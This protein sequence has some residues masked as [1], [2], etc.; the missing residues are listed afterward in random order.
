MGSATAALLPSARTSVSIAQ[1]W[2]DVNYIL[3]DTRAFPICYA[4][5]LYLAAVSVISR[6]LSMMVR[7]SLSCDSVMHNGGTTKIQFQRTKV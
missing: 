2:S 5:P 4:G 1:T 7:P 3:P 6:A